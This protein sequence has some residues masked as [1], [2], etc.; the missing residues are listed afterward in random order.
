MEIDIRIAEEKDKEAWNKVVENSPH[1]TIFH[2][3]E[4]LKIVEKHTGYKLYP[5]LG[6]EENNVLAAFPVFYKKMVFLRSV[7]SPPPKT[8]MPYLG[9][10]FSEYNELKQGKKE[11]RFFELHEKFESFMKSKVRPHYINILL[12]PGILETR[13]FLWSGYQVEPN[14]NYTIDLLKGE[15]EIFKSFKKN[16]R[17]TI[18]ATERKGV[19]IEKGGKDELLVLYD[20]LSDNYKDQ[21]K[22]LPISREYVLDIYDAF[23]PEYMNIFIAKYEGAILGGMVDLHYKEKIYSWIG[24]TKNRVNDLDINDL[25]QWKAIQLGCRE[26]FKTYEIIG[27]NTQRLSFFKTKF[28]PELSVYFSATK[29]SSE[30]VKIPKNAYTRF[31]KPLE[32]KIPSLKIS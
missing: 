18:N 8:A 25:I 1:A 14:Y 15:E 19:V 12:P 11:S 31:Y 32:A 23:F 5:L 6:H 27:A 7:F 26:G 10:V 2:R 20:L 3:W 17:Q 9:P 21:K 30:L 29:Y 22:K 24:N 4:W 28:N 16:L 13:P